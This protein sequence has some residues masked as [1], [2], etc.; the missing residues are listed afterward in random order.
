MYDKDEDGFIDK[1]DMFAL[2]KLMIGNE[3]SE[4]Q[5]SEIVEKTLQDLDEDKDGKLSFEEFSKVIY[6][7][8]LTLVGPIFCITS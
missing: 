4:A 5:I 3:L 7:F 1:N 8:L 6:N 2:M